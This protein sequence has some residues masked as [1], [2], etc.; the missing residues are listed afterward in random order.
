[1]GITLG[2]IM[3]IVGIIGFLLCLALLLLLPSIFAKQKK[4]L[5]EELE[6]DI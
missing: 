5:L 1:M 4:H 6:D 3:F 2:S